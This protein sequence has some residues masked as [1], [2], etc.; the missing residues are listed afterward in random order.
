[1]AINKVEFGDRTLIDLTADSV[2]PQTML[3]GTTAHNPAGEQ[4]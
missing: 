1:M 2:T 4:I 3:K